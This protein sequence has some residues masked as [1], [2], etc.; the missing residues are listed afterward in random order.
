MPN[1]ESFRIFYL[2]YKNRPYFTHWVGWLLF[3]T[4]VVCLN[5]YTNWDTDISTI[6]FDAHLNTFPI[7]QN[8][9]VTLIFH[10]GMR[11]G[12][13]ALWLALLFLAMCQKFKDVIRREIVYLIVVSLLAAL[14]V[15]FLKSESTHSCPWDLAQYGGTADYSRLFEDT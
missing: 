7:K 13:A 12:A 15:S 2:L 10:E 5:R 6:F 11:W 8:L 4:L 1:T 9:L 3:G 14:V